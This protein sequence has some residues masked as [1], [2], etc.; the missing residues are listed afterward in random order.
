M[1]LT[2]VT[3]DHE[4]IRRWA[5]NRRARPCCVRGTGGNDDIGVLRL[6]FPGYSGEDSLQQITWGEWFAKFDER[7]L[8]LLYQEET[9]AGA[10][11]NFNKLVSRQTAE[12]LGNGER[13][14]RK[15]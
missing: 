4:V 6:D 5:D 1:H 2:H 10:K 11:S 9:A 3:T 12:S 13:R 15:S 7:R 14:H 8:A